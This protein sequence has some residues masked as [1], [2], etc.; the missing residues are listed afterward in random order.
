MSEQS[1]EHQLGTKWTSIV[2]DIH[3]S[4][5]ASKGKQ[6]GVKQSELLSSGPPRDLNACMVDFLSMLLRS[7]GPNVFGVDKSKVTGK[8][9]TAIEGSLKLAQH[10][11]FPNQRVAGTSDVSA[12]SWFTSLRDSSNAGDDVSSCAIRSVSSLSQGKECLVHRFF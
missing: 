8:S 2:S 11:K 7:R 6:Q 12:P 1:Q 9:D 5:D 4:R 3:D 10:C